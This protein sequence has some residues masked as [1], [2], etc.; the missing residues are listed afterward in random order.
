MK[1]L[2][3]FLMVMLFATAGFSQ[4]QVASAE[5]E[6]PAG[7]WKF[8]KTPVIFTFG[9]YVK[10]DMIHDFNPIASPD[11]FDVSKIPTDGSKGQTTHFNV[12]ETR[13]KLDVRHPEN[14][15][16]AYIET[17]F[18]GSGSSLRIR[19]AYVEYKGLLV[20]QTWSNFMDESI[21]PPTLDFEKPAAYAFA[22]QGMIRYKHTI[23]DNMYFGIALEESKAEGQAPAEAGK[24]ENS[25]P[26]LTGRFRITEKWGHIQV[27]GYLATIGYRYDTGSR[28]DFT[29]YGGNFS[30]QLNLSKKDKI[31]YQ[32]VY[33]KGLGRYRGGQSVALD[34]NGNLA[35]LTDLGLSIG[36]EHNWTDKF[37]SLFF[38]NYGDVENTEGQPV[39]ALSS[40]TYF[41]TN[42][43][44]N[45]MKGTFVGVEYLRGKRDDFN[46]AN[47]TANRLQF[48]FR[49]SFNM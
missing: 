2:I 18:Y 37:S 11:F 10:A 17:D 45:I 31:I 15:L 7:W 29:L 4:N 40:T 30:G 22:R 34:Q 9:G 19:H 1:N 23:S 49:Y 28:D 13:L 35:P 47:G 14:G 27:S 26:D 46:E 41:A 33:G 20:G 21:I 36:V 16:R 48:S 38:Y 3:M 39:T 25:L 32:A 8:P 44:Y 6:L 24:F 43:I 42:F 5:D 12:K